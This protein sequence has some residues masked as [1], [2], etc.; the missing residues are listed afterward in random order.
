MQ[1]CRGLTSLCSRILG[2]NPT[3]SV[4][5]RQ[6]ANVQVPFFFCRAQSL[7]EARHIEAGVRS[8]EPIENIL[9]IRDTKSHKD[10]QKNGIA[11]ST[12][13]YHC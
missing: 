3:P 12:M 8:I 1:G 11:E 10:K 5:H 7:S 9:G 4:E 6:E 2:F 13:S